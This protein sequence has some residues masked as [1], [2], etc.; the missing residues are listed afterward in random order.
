MLERGQQAMNA[1]QLK[2]LHQ[3][4]AKL[5]AAIVQG[6]QRASEADAQCAQDRQGWLQAQARS[7]LVEKLLQ[8]EQ[9]MEHRAGER[10]AQKQLDEYAQRWPQSIMAPD[11][12]A[13]T[14]SRGP[15]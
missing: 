10:L 6:G 9:M 7:Q 12:D 4:L 8:R 13:D 15:F 11:S 14:S 1:G 5:D 3:F 2:D